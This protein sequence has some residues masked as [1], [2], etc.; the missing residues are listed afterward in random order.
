MVLAS[1]HRRIV[2][3]ACPYMVIV[4]SI[5]KKDAPAAPLFLSVCNLSMGRTMRSIQEIERMRGGSDNVAETHHEQYS[6][7]WVAPAPVPAIAGKNL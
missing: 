7:V 2:H 3:K 5:L 4:G 6:T 1:L